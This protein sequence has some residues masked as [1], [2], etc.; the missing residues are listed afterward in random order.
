MLLTVRVFS[1]VYLMVA[2]RE[3]YVIYVGEYTDLLF[4]SL[5]Q[6]DCYVTEGRVDEALED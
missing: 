4:P 1:H 2:A 5:R 3:Q 6:R